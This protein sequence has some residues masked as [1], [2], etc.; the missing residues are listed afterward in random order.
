MVKVDRCVICASQNLRVLTTH[1]YSRPRAEAKT[2]LN[3]V[4][5]R[6]EILFDHILTDRN[7]AEF[8]V[9]LCAACGMIFTNP[10]FTDEEINIKYQAIGRIESHQVRTAGK[11]LDLA[12]AKAV[13]IH[14]V[15]SNLMDLNRAH[16]PKRI[17]DYGGAGGTNVAPFVPGGHHCFLLDYVEYPL[18]ARVTR[19]GRDLADLDDDVQFDVILLLHVLEHCTRPNDIIAEL[20]RYLADD[21]LLCVHVPLGC[22]REWKY[23]KEPLTHVNFF[24]E[25]SLLNCV[26]RADLDVAHLSTKFQYAVSSQRLCVNLI[27]RKCDSRSDIA[28]KST[29]RQMVQPYHTLES[30]GKKIAGR[31]FRR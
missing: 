11:D 10:R 21:G 4:D 31:V 15:I 14:R 6:L 17:L 25:Q 12:E 5:S 16:S 9:V 8:D 1:T 20:T 30:W 18:P 7:S 28:F 19:L 24:S 27:A 13:E 29:R 26:R 2:Q 22:W 3:Y 23:L